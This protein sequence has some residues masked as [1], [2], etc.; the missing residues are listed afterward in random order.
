MPPKGL[1]KNMK[2]QGK[3]GL[4][5][6]SSSGIG[7]AIAVRLAN[8]GADIVVHYSH[9]RQG[10]EETL[11]RVKAAGRQGW[12]VQA[13][14]S[15]THETKN[16]VSQAMADAGGLDILVNNAGREK[17]AAFWEVTEEDYDTVV[18]LNLKGVFFATQTVVKHLL[19]TQR[20]GKIINISSV[21][22]DL[23]FPGFAPYCISKGGMR[24]LTRNLAVELGPYGI[25][26]NAIAPGAI[27]TPINRDLLNDPPKLDALLDQIPLKRLGQP[28]DVAGLAAFL[29]SPDADY[30]TGA[31]YFVDGGLT[32]HYEE[33]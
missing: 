25:T 11:D 7:Q 8:E 17:R 6:G 24:M 19:A 14:L 10:A 26:I 9:N 28:H 23:P 2:L 20:P 33:Q 3:V 4:V 16:A 22:E 15:L 31:T 29:A 32:W 18:D 12:I 27:Q 21:H 5:T 1:V 30:I 13:D